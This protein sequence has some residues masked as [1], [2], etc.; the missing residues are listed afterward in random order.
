MQT[1]DVGRIVAI[2]QVGGLH[3]RYEPENSDAI[4]I[5]GIGQ[6][7]SRHSDSVRSPIAGAIFLVAFDATAE[8]C[9]NV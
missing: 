3:H 1:A 2:P 7:N 4:S 9:P 6:A 8:A 5:Q